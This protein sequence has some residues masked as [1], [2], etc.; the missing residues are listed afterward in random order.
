MPQGYSGAPAR[1]YFSLCD[2]AMLEAQNALARAASSMPLLPIPTPRWLPYTESDAEF[3]GGVTAGY[4]TSAY[5]V[6]FT[7]EC[8]FTREMRFI[9]YGRWERHIVEREAWEQERLERREQYERWRT[10][11]RRRRG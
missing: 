7:R 1:R 2:E 10:R 5:I 6:G 8:S 4:G 9:Q 3:R 11:E